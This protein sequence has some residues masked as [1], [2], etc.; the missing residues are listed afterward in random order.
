MAT[1]IVLIDIVHQT[2]L[3]P[4]LLVVVYLASETDQSILVPPLRGLGAINAILLFSN[5][6]D[7]LEDLLCFWPEK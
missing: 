6:T 5:E 2:M 3:L 1:A 7:R 4:K